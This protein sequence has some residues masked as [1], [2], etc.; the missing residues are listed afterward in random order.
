MQFNLVADVLRMAWFQRRQELG[1]IFH[2]DRGSQYCSHAFQQALVEYHMRF[3]TIRQAMDE[4]IDWLMFYNQG[5][6]HSTLGYISPM[7]FEQ[8]WS[9]ATAE[10]C[11][12][13]STLSGT[14]YRGKVRLRK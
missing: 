2:S 8:Y 6:L 9:A 12:I 5:K 3:E 7:H 10:G 4:V 11:R 13:M 1:L 14:E